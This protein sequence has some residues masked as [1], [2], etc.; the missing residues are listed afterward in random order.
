LKKLKYLKN[1]SIPRFA[2]RLAVS[3]ALRSGVARVRSI[4]IPAVKSNAIRKTRISTYFG[5]NAM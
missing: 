1:P 5:M 4:R 3:S 2:T